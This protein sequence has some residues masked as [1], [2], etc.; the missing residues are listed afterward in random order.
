M[1]EGI[2]W[3]FRNSEQSEMDNEVTYP[4]VERATSK[5]A[6]LPAHIV[7]FLRRSMHTTVY[8]GDTR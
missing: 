2:R 4:W 8:G 1:G 5:A 3:P 6:G 7:S